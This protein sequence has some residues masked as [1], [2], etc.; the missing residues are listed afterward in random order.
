MVEVKIVKV[1]KLVTVNVKTPV[2]TLHL[3]AEELVMLRVLVGNVAGSGHM[4]E[5]SDRVFGNLSKV[6]PTEPYFISRMQ[7]VAASFRED[8]KAFDAIVKGLIEKYAS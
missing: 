8:R 5:I 1:E 3:N 7:G 4:R 2:F 6:V